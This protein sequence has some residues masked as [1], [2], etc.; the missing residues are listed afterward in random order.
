MAHLTEKKGSKF[1]PFVKTYILVKPLFLC[2]IYVLNIL[3]AFLP[4]FICFVCFFN[5]SSGFN[6]LPLDLQTKAQSYTVFTDKLLSGFFAENS[7]L[8]YFDI[9]SFLLIAS[10]FLNVR[11]I[12]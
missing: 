6:R 2:E 10:S 8:H 11:F 9:I 1:T 12:F 5:K 4:I 3:C 7:G